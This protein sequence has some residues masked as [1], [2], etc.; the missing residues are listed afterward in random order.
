VKRRVHASGRMTPRLHVLLTVGPVP[1]LGH[2]VEG[3]SP[4]E[5]EAA[6][7]GHRDW[8]LDPRRNLPGTRPWAWWQYQVIE[9]GMADASPDER[10]AFLREHDLLRQ[11][12]LV[13]LDAQRRV[14]GHTAA[15][16]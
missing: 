3:E 16:T 10:L 1:D 2:P 11:D 9:P 5:L 15:V 13:A 14:N 8:L 7:W 6:W 4:D 12:E